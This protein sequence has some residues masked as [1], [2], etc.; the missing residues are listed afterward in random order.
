MKIFLGEPLKYIEV[1]YVCYSPRQNPSFD[2]KW[3]WISAQVYEDRE[4][5]SVTLTL[6]SLKK[7]ALICLIQPEIMLDRDVAQI[8]PERSSTR[9]R[10]TFIN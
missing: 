1:N 3:D 8:R 2:N 7:I 10:R 6:S 5:V 4:Q 9:C